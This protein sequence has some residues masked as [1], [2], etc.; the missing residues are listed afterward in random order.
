MRCAVATISALCLLASCQAGEWQ[1][2]T[3][4]SHQAEIIGG[5]GAPFDDAVVAVFVGGLCTGTL[6][7]PRIVLT[8]AHCVGDAIEAGQTSFGSVRFGD[9]TGP[10]IDSIPVAD[11]TMHRFYDPPAFLEWDI[12]LLR[13]ARPA[14][15]NITPLPISTRHL[16]E[17]DEGLRVRVV[18]YGNT[19]G[20][21]D[22]NPASGAGQ[23]RQVTLPLQVVRPTH[24]VFGNSQQNTC[25]GDSGGPSF[26]LFDG[27][28][29]VIGVTS[30]GARGCGGD[31]AMTRTDAMW[32]D[33]LTEVISAW[34]GPC[35]HD[36]TCVTDGCAYPDPDCDPCGFDGVCAADCPKPDRDCPTVG[37]ATDFCDTDMDCEGRLCIPAFED[38]RIHYC[39]TACDPDAPSSDTGCFPPLGRCD[40]QDDGTGVCR[41][42]GAT[43]SAQGA[44]CNTPD[45]CRSGVCDVD[46]G[47]CVEQCGE[48]L[49][50]CI[51][52]FQCRTYDSGQFCS[53]PQTNTGGCGC[54]SS[55][56]SAPFSAIGFLFGLLALRRRTRGKIVL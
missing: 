55:H 4:E 38:E 8:A 25:Q 39:S 54:Q 29:Y 37:R 53:I 11:M 15:E 5:T 41:F 40:R 17:D 6:V 32:D 24:I 3:L 18:G 10:W 22:E 9:G 43:P 52:G 16:T 28:E 20:G 35:Q 42:N 27:E 48:G 19:F 23:R 2:G 47:I 14:P 34:S 46:E 12:A 44:G 21:D 26:G 51:D 1:E 50:D 30:Y 7:A 33:F 49:P 36:G 45:D 56:S 13:L 31:S